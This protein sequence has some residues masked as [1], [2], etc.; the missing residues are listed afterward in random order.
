MEEV[1]KRLLQRISTTDYAAIWLTAKEDE[2]PVEG[3][4]MYLSDLSEKLELPLSRVSKIV[5][6]LQERGLVTWEHEGNGEDGTYILITERGARIAQERKETAEQ[7]YRDVIQQFG[8]I[9]FAA[10]LKEL[11]ELD[12][13]MNTELEKMGV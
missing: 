5:K 7:I 12:E 10:L 9:R 3:E 13:I 1:K 11:S 6:S 4:K 2:L 8:E